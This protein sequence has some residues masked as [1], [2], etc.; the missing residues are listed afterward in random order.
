VGEVAGDP[1]LELAL[2]ILAQFLMGFC[3]FFLFIKQI[4]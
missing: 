4:F 3:L 2:Q 1:L